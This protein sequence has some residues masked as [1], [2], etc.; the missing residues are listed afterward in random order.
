M[1][2]D[3]PGGFSRRSFVKT[4]TLATAGLVMPRSLSA[5]QPDPLSAEVIRVGV[6]GCGGRGSGAARDIMRA[7]GDGVQIVAMGDLFPDRLERARSNLAK[8]ASEDPMVARQFKVIP[9]KLFSGFDAYQKVLAS[10]IDLVILAT[11][12]GFRPMHLAAAVAAGKHIFMEKPVAV[13][14]VGVRSVMASAAAAKAKSLAIVAGTQRRHQPEYLDVMKRVQDGA[15]GELTGGQVY[16]NQGGLWNAAR[17]AD[18]SDAEWQIRNWLYFT[19]LS[20][21]HIVEQHIHNID[22][23]NWAMGAHPVR[24]VG[25]GGRQWRTD[26]AFGHIFDH[27]AIN[28]EYPNGAQVMSMCR[29]IDGSANFVGERFVGTRGTTDAYS[30]IA[31]A[32]PYKRERS[33]KNAYVE[34]HVDLLASIRQGTPLNEGQQVAEST[35]SAILGREAAYTG[36]AIVWDELL[37]A[38][39]DLTPP[40]KGFGQLAVPP[41]AM[42]GKTRVARTFN[43]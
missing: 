38:T 11:P 33:E 22:V 18:W 9:E 10:D 34:E 35:L 26:G 6:I 42:P 4:T 43:D 24:A 17:Q 15:I 8:V 3:T 7:G 32:Q 1:H 25:I 29:Q 31:G 20:G 23:A 13:D 12:P 28:F 39:Q 30:T 41:V 37:N 2:D 16:W 5:M 21:D 40:N 27:F 19:W 14:A 36:Q